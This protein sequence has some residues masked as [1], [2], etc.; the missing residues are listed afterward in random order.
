MRGHIRAPYQGKQRQVSE[1]KTFNGSFDFYTTQQREKEKEI[2]RLS[3]L[4]KSLEA[5]NKIIQQYEEHHATLIS[6]HLELT[7]CKVASVEPS[8]SGVRIA[9]EDYET[10][11]ER[12]RKSAQFIQA[13]HDIIKQFKKL[14]L[15]DKFNF[16][17]TGSNNEGKAKVLWHKEEA[18]RVRKETEMLYKEMSQMQRDLAWKN[19]EI[20]RLEGR[21]SFFKDLEDQAQKL[22]E[23]S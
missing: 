7:L 12:L 18:K 5:F 9:P 8:S 13:Q 3:R 17:F 19:E 2:K 10:L 20:R 4:A 22:Q 14:I 1:R 11:V 16:S 15:D 21:L 6:P 23:D